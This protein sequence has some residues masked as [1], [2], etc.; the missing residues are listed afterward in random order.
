ME[1]E[2]PITQSEI[3]E[4]T[5]VP[6]DQNEEQEQENNENPIELQPNEEPREVSDTESTQLSELSET[7]RSTRE[8]KPVERLTYSHMNGKRI[9]SIDGKTNNKS[10]R[11]VVRFSEDTI[12]HNKEKEYYY[13]KIWK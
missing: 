6:N 1:S 5:G 2:E 7:R 12:I 8:T 11:K 9:K 13:A 3:D 4:I 10:K